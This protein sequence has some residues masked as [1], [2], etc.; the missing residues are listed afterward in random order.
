M[1]KYKLYRIFKGGVWF[2]Y[3]YIYSGFNHTL[4]Q[5]FIWSQ[6]PLNIKNYNLIDTENYE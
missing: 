5:D 2:R 3:K 4:N 1:N 6:K